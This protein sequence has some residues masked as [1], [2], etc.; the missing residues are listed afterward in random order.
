[1]NN[2]TLSA[3]LNEYMQTHYDLF[4]LAFDRLGYPEARISPAWL[5]RIYNEQPKTEEALVA[6]A[7]DLEYPELFFADFTSGIES[8]EMIGPPPPPTKEEKKGNDKKGNGNAA[9]I[10]GSVGTGLGSILNGIFGK[11]PTNNYY[12]NSPE[13]NSG[14]SNNNTTTYILIAVG[15]LGLGVALYFILKK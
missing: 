2:I 11:A 4:R 9:E 3:Q 1:M 13:S 12:T 15:V 6:A 5:N 14:S 8:E 10:I 7:L